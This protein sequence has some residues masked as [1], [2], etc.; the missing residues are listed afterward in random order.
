[1]VAPSPQKEEMIRKKGWRL[2]NSS[3]DEA[4]LKTAGRV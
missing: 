1:M 4:V 3:H 2:S